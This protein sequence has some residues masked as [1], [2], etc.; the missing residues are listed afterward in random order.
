M[1]ELAER[2]LKEIA[3]ALHGHPGLTRE[4]FGASEEAALLALAS[5]AST[6]GLTAERDALQ[7]LWIRLPDDDGIRTCRADRD[8]TSTRYRR[9]ATTTDWRGVVSGILVLHEILRQGRKPPRPV[10]VLAMRA[11]ESAWYGKAY[12]RLARP[13]RPTRRNFELAAKHRNGDKTLA[14]AMAAAVSTWTS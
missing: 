3:D 14:E 5:Q 9:E 2:L 12:I 11:E 4:C 13:V 6:L 1:H 10:R 7:N 8:R